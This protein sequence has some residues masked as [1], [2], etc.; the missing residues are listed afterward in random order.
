VATGLAVAR[1]PGA[2]RRL[3]RAVGRKLVARPGARAPLRR[4]RRSPA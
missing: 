4:R 1:A 3:R 2:G